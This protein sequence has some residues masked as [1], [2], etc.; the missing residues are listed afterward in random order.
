MTVPLAA[1]NFDE[2]GNRVADPRQYGAF[3]KVRGFTVPRHFV[4]WSQSDMPEHMLR[5][6]LA[7]LDQAREHVLSALGSTT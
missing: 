6:M 1:L 2:N 4:K 7:Q 5:G 3:I